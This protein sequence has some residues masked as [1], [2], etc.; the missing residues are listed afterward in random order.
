[1]N[2]G[3]KVVGVASS[4]SIETVQQENVQLGVHILA[5]SSVLSRNKT[6]QVFRAINTAG[7]EGFLRRH[8][9]SRL[10]VVRA[11]TVGNRQINGE[12]D[13][14]TQELWVNARRADHTYAQEFSLGKTRTVSALAPTILEAI[15]RSLIHELAHHVYK[16]RIFGTALEGAIVQAA[17]SGTPLTFRA[18]AGVK[19]YFAECFTA[20]TYEPDLLKKHDPVGYAMIERVRGELSLP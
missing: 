3:Y 19:E 17:R 2:C 6:R 5:S 4:N 8:P 20:Y 16:Q 1:M 12:Y 10:D 9:L 18:S 7:L 11:K 15:R 14:D 13:E